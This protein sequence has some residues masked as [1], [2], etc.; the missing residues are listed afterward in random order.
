[1]CAVGVWPVRDLCWSRGPWQPKVM[2]RSLCHTWPNLTP[3]RFVCVCMHACMCV[4]AWVCMQAW[5]SVWVRAREREK[6]CVR[7]CVCAGVH[8]CVSVCV[9]C[10]CCSNWCLNTI[11]HK[12]VFLTVRYRSLTDIDWFA[13]SYVEWKKKPRKCVSSP[14]EIFVKAAHLKEL[15]FFV[16][17]A[18]VV[19]TYHHS[20]TF[21]PSL[22]AI[23]SSLLSDHASTG[24]VLQWWPKSGIHVLDRWLIKVATSILSAA[25]TFLH[26]SCRMCVIVC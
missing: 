9:L 23:F 20:G 12:Q 19:T 5:M 22:G 1:M 17:S 16:T 11:P 26:F 25:I 10:S 24:M 14:Q 2:Y 7:V 6:V 18:H 21:C 13:P 15:T 8:E 3:V 4:C